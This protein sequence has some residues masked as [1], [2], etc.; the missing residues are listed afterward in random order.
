M[1]ISY[2][3]KP[4]KGRGLL[5]HFSEELNQFLLNRLY[6]KFY[7]EEGIGAR[8]ASRVLAGL[9]SQWSWGKSLHFMSSFSGVHLS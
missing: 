8:N 9:G 3:H 5:A 6:G 1:P 2:L 4:D 7:M